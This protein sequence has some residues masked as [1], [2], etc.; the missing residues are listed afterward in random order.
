MKKQGL[1]KTLYKSTII[2][3][4]IFIVVII[5]FNSLLSYNNFLNTQESIKENIINTKKTILKN[6]IDF[7]LSDFEVSKDKQKEMIK[8][9]IKQRVNVAFDIAQNLYNTQKD[10]SNI[11]NIIIESLR[12]LKFNDIGDQYIFMTKLDGEILLLNTLE[13]LEGKNLLGLKNPVNKKI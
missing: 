13:N 4:S 10:N 1:Y 9:M 2:L 12:K 3:F 11:Q 5:L 7:F 8:E 6:E